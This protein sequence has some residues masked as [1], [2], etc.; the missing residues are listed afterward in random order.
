MRE[1]ETCSIFL[2]ILERERERERSIGKERHKREKE[3]TERRKCEEI[4]EESK[5]FSHV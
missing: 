1:R 3:T 5:V 2:Y 4:V